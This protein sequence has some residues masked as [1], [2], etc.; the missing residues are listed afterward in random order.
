MAAR[1]HDP[2]HSSKLELHGLT[3]AEAH[4]AINTYAKHVELRV[5][6]RAQLREAVDRAHMD[7]LPL[8]SEA[9]Q[10]QA[11]RT[12]N[13]RVRLIQDEG[14][15]TYHSLARMRG[16]GQGGAR[17]WANRLRRHNLLFTVEVNGKTL[18]PMVQLTTDGQLDE[19]V[20]E[21]LINPLLSAGMEPWS[22]WSWLTS[23]TGL[24]SGGLSAVIV[25]TAMDRVDRAVQRHIADL[26]LPAGA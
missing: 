26:A 13:A 4:E 5:H 24:L 6:M 12:A 9:T 2:A 15:A 17:P 1:A 7:D 11:K 3:Q 25:H 16:T 10:N 22:L 8:V 23:P 20:S 18:I 14:A 21:H 19:L